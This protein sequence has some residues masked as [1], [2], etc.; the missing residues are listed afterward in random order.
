MIEVSEQLPRTGYTKQTPN[1][2]LLGA[3]SIVENLEWDAETQ[4]WSYDKIGATSGGNKLTLKNE[5]RQAQIDGVL[6]KTVGSDQI[7]STEGTFEINAIEF[8]AENFKRMLLAETVTDA[9]ETAKYPDT[10]D[11]IKPKDR[12][13]SSVYVKN[14]AYIGRVQGSNENIV[15]I[16]HNAICTSGLEIEPKDGEDNII[17]MTFEARAGEDDIESASLPITILYPKDLNGTVAG[18]SMKQANTTKK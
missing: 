4:K 13:D 5:Y 7:E 1:L 11:V 2:F 3:G 6:A 12:I 16:M 18:R 10:Y 17:P 14:L 15:V 8:T 9:E